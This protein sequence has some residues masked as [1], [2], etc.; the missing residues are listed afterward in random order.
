MHLDPRPRARKTSIHGNV[1]SAAAISRK[2]K[3]TK[4]NVFPHPCGSLIG[5]CDIHK[6]GCDTSAG[7]HDILKGGC[8]ILKGGCETLKVSMT[9]EG[10]RDILEGGCDIL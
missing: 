7:G 2:H 4:T 1:K 8:D 6:G 9:L 3:N 5:S 10:G